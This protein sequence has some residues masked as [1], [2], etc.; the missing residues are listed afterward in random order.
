MEKISEFEFTAQGRRSFYEW[1]TILDGSIW[2]LG[3]DELKP[4]KSGKDDS[5]IVVLG[6][7]RRAAYAAARSRGLVIQTQI[8]GD[9]IVIQAQ[10]KE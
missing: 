9:S 1:D 3:K 10:P 6:R 4:T 8:D 5:L 7:F 2:R